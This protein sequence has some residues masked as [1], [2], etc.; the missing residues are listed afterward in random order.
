MLAS[1]IRQIAVTVGL[2]G[3]WASVLGLSPAKAQIPLDAVDT[4]RYGH[5]FDR[6]HSPDLLPC[7]IHPLDPKLDWAFR[8]QVTYL[9]NCPQ[10]DFGG[11]A[12]ELNILTRVTP[13]G[14]KPFLFRDNA[15]MPVPNPGDDVSKIDLRIIQ[16][17]LAGEGDYQ[18]E[19]LVEEQGT[20]RELRKTWHLRAARA[21]D[22]QDTQIAILPNTATFLTA[23]RPSIKMDTGG[24]GLRIT[25]LMDVAPLNPRSTELKEYDQAF[26][27]GSLVAIVS[28]AQ[29]ASVRLRA[30]N[31]DQQREL[32]HE[33]L[34]DD[35]GFTQLSEALRN[36]RLGT[37]SSRFLG[38]NRGWRRML[39]SY[40]N[41]ELTAASPADAVIFLGP[42]VRY[43]APVPRGKLQAR[44]SPKP[45]FYY[46]QRAAPRPENWGSRLSHPNS[47]GG[48]NGCGRVSTP[49]EYPADIPRVVNL[50]NMYPCD[51]TSSLHQPP[52]TLSLVTK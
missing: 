14:S 52:D 48:G 2:V 43:E 27:L 12:S 42:Y 23:A 16:H 33:E 10:R 5:L 45:H 36:L 17:I 49:E 20:G 6:P 30:F 39:L 4:E 13:G 37:V 29:P 11:K 51:V 41:L 46:F 35:A 9:V 34:F 1:L 25:I 32:F 19:V 24:K 26:L 38:P 47:P 50:G 40:V 18:V 7:S 44:V 28:Q 3:L 8:F 22:E 15:R 21:R 31:L